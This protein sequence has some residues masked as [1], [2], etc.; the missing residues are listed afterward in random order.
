LS[1]TGEARSL[2]ALSDNI[3]IGSW[4]RHQR[5]RFNRLLLEAIFQEKI[6]KSTPYALKPSP[7]PRYWQPNEPVVLIADEAGSNI[8]RPTIRHGQ[9][10]RQ[11]ADGLL[12]CTV[13]RVPDKAAI[14]QHF[15]AIRKKISELKPPLGKE[16]IGFG[17]WKEQPWHPILLEW[18]VEVM[19]LRGKYDDANLSARHPLSR[20]F[21]PKFITD[22]YILEENAVDFVIRQGK[23]SV[24]R[25]NARYFGRSILTPHAKHQM[26]NQIRNLLEKQLLEKYYSDKNILPA[27]RTDHYFA[28]NINEIIAWACN[29]SDPD[30][31]QIIDVYNHL[32]AKDDNDD[33]S[34]TF[35]ILAQSLT[36]FNEALLMQKQ[37]LQLPIRD[38]SGVR[39][40]SNVHCEGARC[41]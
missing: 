7:A 11:R 22:N 36:G 20:N 17:V 1:L 27:E 5:F 12:A 30:M 40:L 37:T 8:V 10:G 18:E 31:N 25:E 16:R 32:D 28:E 13:L 33:E 34:A 38:P 9:D 41:C 21:D 14:E 29:I 35:H 15:D 6:K 26:L 2:V 19:P 39:G 4:P 24:I 23:E 3:P